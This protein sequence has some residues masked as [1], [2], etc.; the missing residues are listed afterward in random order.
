VW[1]HAI[2]RC[3]S[4]HHNASGQ[5]LSSSGLTSG[6]QSKFDPRGDFRGIRRF[7]RFE[8]DAPRWHLSRA[9]VGHLDTAPQHVGNGGIGKFCAVTLR[10]RSEVGAD[11]LNWDDAGGDRL[12]FHRLRDR[13]RNTFCRVPHQTLYS[14]VLGAF[15]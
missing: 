12:L 8:R 5:Q 10:Q 3:R 7:R 15:F 2:G 11:S 13:R 6:S 4:E 14:Y 1:L 9:M